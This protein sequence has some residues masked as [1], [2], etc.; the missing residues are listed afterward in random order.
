MIKQTA[1]VKTRVGSED[2]TQG[3]IGLPAAIAVPPAVYT[4]RAALHRSGGN[5]VF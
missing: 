5:D 2:N 1:R 4:D 3:Q